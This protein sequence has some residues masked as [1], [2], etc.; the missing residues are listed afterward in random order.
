MVRSIQNH[1]NCVP[2]ILHNNLNAKL[3]RLDYLKKPY[4][5]SILFAFKELKRKRL[6]CLLNF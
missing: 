5:V 4:I 3:N 6:R 2:N 1:S